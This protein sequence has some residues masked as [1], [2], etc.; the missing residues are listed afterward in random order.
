MGLEDSIHAAGQ[1]RENSRWSLPDAMLVQ[2]EASGAFF[3]Q[4]Q[5]GGG[6]FIGHGTDKELGLIMVV[7]RGWWE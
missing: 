4:V 7:E 3:H 2:P 1:R 5:G 6:K